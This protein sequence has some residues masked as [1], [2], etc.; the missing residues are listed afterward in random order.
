LIAPPSL[1][2]NPRSLTLAFLAGHAGD[3]AAASAAA[4]PA[5]AGAEAGFWDLVAALESTIP[6]DATT[7]AT[8]TTAPAAAAAATANV[9]D[10]PG[11]L[12]ELDHLLQAAAEPTLARNVLA[13]AFKGSGGGGGGGGG[14]GD[15]ATLPALTPALATPSNATSLAARSNCWDVGMNLAMGMGMD[16][17]MDVNVVPV[18][19]NAVGVPSPSFDDSLLADPAVTALAARLLQ[20]KEAFASAERLVH[21]SC[22]AKAAGMV[23]RVGATTMSGKPRK[24]GTPGAP[25]QKRK[26]K[27][28]VPDHLKD[29]KYWRKRQANTEA[30]RRTRG[31]AKLQKNFQAN[32]AVRAADAKRELNVLMKRTAVASN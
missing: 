17:G 24:V 18:A 9:A 3:E 23:G 2:E 28:E 29:A 14:G 27:I 11:F 15:F 10:S 4:A 13:P 1:P 20:D 16:M 8:V 21:A 6:A 7:D 30:A 12:L 32:A 19:F 25:K 5:A 26:P 31:R 22:Q